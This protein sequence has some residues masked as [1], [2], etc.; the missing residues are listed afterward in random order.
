M[1]QNDIVLKSEKKLDSVQFN[2][3]YDRNSHFPSDHNSV[4]PEG[5]KI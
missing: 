1:L 3:I 5:E 4:M 2:Q